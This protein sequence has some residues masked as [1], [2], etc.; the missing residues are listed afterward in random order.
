M[1][2]VTASLAALVAGY[3]RIVT[4]RPNARVWWLTRGAQRVSDVDLPAP[5]H[6]AA[7]A[8][9]KVLPI[10]RPQSW[11][12][13]MDLEAGAPASDMASMIASVLTGEPGADQVALRGR[14]YLAAR[15]MPMTV[16]EAPSRV[17]LPGDATILVTGGL[18]GL[19]LES[20]R[21]LAARGARHLLLAGRTTPDAS[22]DAMV[23]ELSARGVDVRVVSLD[24]AD[25]NAVSCVARAQQDA[26]RPPIRGV[27]HA[28][29][30]WEDQP[31]ASLTPAALARVLA[32]KVDGTLALTRA[33]PDLDVFIG[34]SAFSVLLPAETQGNYAAANAF[35]DA[36]VATEQARAPR[37]WVSVHWGPWAGVGF[38]T[39]DYGRRAHDRLQALGISRITAPDGFLALDALMA[40]GFSGVGLMPVDWRRLFDRDPHARLAPL[41]RELSQRHAI[42]ATSEAGRVRDLLSGLSN[43][44][45]T[46]RLEQE[47]TAMAA[48]IM[49]LSA[50]TIDRQVS[51]TDLGLDSLMAVELKNRIRHDV[52]VD[53]PLVRLLSGPSMAELT[54]LVSVQRKMADLGA[55]SPEGADLT[56]VEI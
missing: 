51:F 24:V 40:G 56:E 39:T 49:Q 1:E 42:V 55:A 48:G 14:E 44:D 15:L 50:A 18:R 16:P 46:A 43:T 34:F 7:W 33:L 27:V 13:L 8:M 9:L 20:A 54:V 17:S 2:D 4:C 37:Q 19:G 10:E 32:P 52:G 25:P 53:I 22:T 31:L 23:A 47:L 35:M 36:F 6:A 11:G 29:G 5:L 45:A 3:Q 38:A 21:W 30:V 41:L 26:G 12:G 28:A